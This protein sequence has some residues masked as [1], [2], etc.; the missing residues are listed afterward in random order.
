[1]KSV[2]IIGMGTLGRHLARK[3]VE[4]GNEVMIMDEDE[5][6]IQELAQEFPN[7]VAGDCPMTKT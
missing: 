2:L 7:A 3:I 5:E 4:F 6:V 1:M